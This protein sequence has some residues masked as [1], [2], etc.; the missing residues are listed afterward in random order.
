MSKKTPGVGFG[1]MLLKDNKI[2]LGHRH[3]DPKK[4]D[5]AL[6]GEGTWTL[7]GGKLDFGENFED[8]AAREVMEETGINIEKNKLELISLTNN[9]VHDAHFVTMGWLCHNFTGESQVLEPDEITEWKWFALEDLPEPMY[10]PSV[11]VLEN[12]QTGK[13]YKHN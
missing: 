11:E 8:A 9:V 3:I 2:L 12:Y 4:A 7:P 10:K 5:S 6:H 1:V 13:I